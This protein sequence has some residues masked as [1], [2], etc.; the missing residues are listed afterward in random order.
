[1]KRPL[2]LLLTG[3]APAFLS[4]CMSAGGLAVGLDRES[5]FLRGDL[6]AETRKT[7]HQ[8]ADRRM[9]QSRLGSAQDREA[10]L[11]TGGVTPGEEPELN[12]IQQDIASLKKQLS[13][14][15]AAG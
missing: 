7:D 5:Q 14:L 8:L 12:K 3:L 9:L 13:A 10:E 11:R 15:A 6:D 2:I 1:M 4:S